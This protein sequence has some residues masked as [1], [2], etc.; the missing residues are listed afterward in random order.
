RGSAAGPRPGGERRPDPRGGE[1]RLAQE[2]AVQDLRDLLGAPGG[3]ARDRLREGDRAGAELPPTEDAPPA[4]R[5]APAE[6]ERGR[7][8]ARRRPRVRGV[9]SRRGPPPRDR[10][11]AAL[12]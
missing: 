9:A 3:R 11:G 12:A 1:V 6:A 10:E 7:L 8:G 4:S 5:G 2:R